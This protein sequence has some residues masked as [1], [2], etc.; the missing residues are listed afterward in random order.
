MISCGKY[1]YT[2]Q[3]KKLWQST[4]GDSTAYINSFF[5]DIYQDENTLVYIENN[6]VVSALYIIEYEM[7][8]KSDK[9]K[10][11][12]FYA[13]A[14][15]P[16]YRGQGIMSRLIERAFESCAKRDYK[17]CVL[18][19]SEAS[20]FD[21]YRR[22]GFKECFYRTT[23]KKYLPEIRTASGEKE[24]L[25]KRAGFEKIWNAYINSIFFGP[26]C[27]VLSKQQN[28]FFIKELTRDGGQAFVFDL[29]GKDD[30]YI[31]LGHRDKELIIY[32]TN[33]IAEIVPFLYSAFLKSFSFE[34]LEFYQP[35][36]FPPEELAAGKSRYA[37]CKELSELK[38]EN[39]F[40]NRV[41]T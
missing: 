26:E 31:L 24:L 17:L 13:L 34:S 25:L 22:F 20:L 19:P 7:P 9:I 5:D 14:T 18:I 23:V 15:Q 32:E 16:E 4:F 38:L 36:C 37:M 3:L 6:A 21:Y 1:E 2:Q 30:G 33:A 35:L 11:A 27:V 39:P 29:K 8:L 28:D 10:I 41:L 40:I 12:Y